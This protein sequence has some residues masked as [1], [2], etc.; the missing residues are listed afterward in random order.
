MTYKRVL[1]KELIVISN[2]KGLKMGDFTKKVKGYCTAHTDNPT[3]VTNLSPTTTVVEAKIES[4]IEIE[5]ERTEIFKSYMQKTN[6]MNS[7]KRDVTNDINNGWCNQVQNAVAG[8]TSKV[9]L[10]GYG[11]K[12]IINGASPANALIGRAMESYPSIS[13]IVSTISCQHKIFTRNSATGKVK[14]PSDAK[15]IEIYMQIGGLTPPTEIKNMS[16]LGSCT[17]GNLINKFDTADIGKI[18]YYIAVYMDKK[19]KKPIGFS[20]VASAMV[21]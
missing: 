21:N 3:I 16:H 13:K 2:L 8:D 11:I 14:L 15:S 4:I 19:T 1:K 9:I 5:A 6:L 10:L 7:I 20:H 18:V 12:G 17:R